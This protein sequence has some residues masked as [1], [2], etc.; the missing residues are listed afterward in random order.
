MTTFQC[1]TAVSWEA[2]EGVWGLEPRAEDQEGHQAEVPALSKHHS[3][4][5]L[6]LN[7]RKS[8]QAQGK[9]TKVRG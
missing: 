4:G 3:S 9:Q 5:T 2:D 8:N 7:T 6:D 1:K